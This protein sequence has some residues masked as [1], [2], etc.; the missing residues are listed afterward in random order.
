MT[1]SIE[2]TREKSS[3]KKS[4]KTRAKVDKK[5][6]CKHKILIF[7][8]FGVLTR[9]SEKNNFQIELTYFK[10]L[11]FLVTSSQSNELVN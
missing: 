4:R 9:K 3:Q 10:S 11:Y 2:N 5:K 7:M 6:H 8:N 1:F